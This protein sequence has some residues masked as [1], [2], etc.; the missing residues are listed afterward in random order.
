MEIVKY[1]ELIVSFK[2]ALLEVLEINLKDGGLFTMFNKDILFY[3]CQIILDRQGIIDV[4]DRPRIAIL[5]NRP[6]HSTEDDRNSPGK[7]E[8]ENSRVMVKRK[9]FEQVIHVMVPR[10]KMFQA[11]PYGNPATLEPTT[12]L[13]ADRVWQNITAMLHF[14]RLT[15]RDRGI[16]KISIDDFPQENSDEQWWINTG[17][18]TADIQFAIPME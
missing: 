9:K 15:L 2:L 7:C 3:K 14:H 8:N 16:W 4:S 17:K 5:G 12:K 13:M 11:P 1:P 10:G 18:L 6:F